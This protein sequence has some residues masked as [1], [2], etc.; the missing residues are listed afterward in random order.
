[1]N[2]SAIDST[3]VSVLPL[4]SLGPGDAGIAGAKAATLARLLRAGFPVPD[5]FVV[6][7][8]T[9]VTADS[10]RAAI[11]AS[12]RSLGGGPV[13]VRSSAV[14]EDLDDASFAGQYETILGVIGIDAVCEAIAAVRASAGSLRID[15]YRSERA[16]GAEDGIGVLVQ[17]LVPATASGVAFTA[18]PVSGD[19]T[20]VRVSAVR[21]LG[22]RLVG[23]E[24]QADEWRVEAGIAAAVRDRQGAIDANLA[25]AVADLARRIEA[26]EGRPQDIE[27]AAVDGSI[28]VLQARPMTA[29]P[30][31]VSWDPGHRGV[32]LRNFRLGEWLG[33]PV[34]PLFETWLLSRLESRLNRNLAATISVA[35][36][37]PEHLV[38]NGWY[39]YGFNVIPSRPARMLAMMLRHVLPSLLRRPRRAAMAFPP[40]ARFGVGLAER[41]WRERVAPRY[42]RAVEDADRD[43][44]TADP[45]RLV[46]IVDE[47]ADAAG[48]YFTSITMVAGFASKSE[49]PLARFHRRYLVAETGGSHLD[50]LSGLGASA[51]APRRHAVGSIDWFAP[52]IAETGVA[53]DASATVQ[54][55][56]AARQRRQAAEAVAR[57]ALAGASRLRRFE[58]L[59]G[60]AQRYAVIR[61]EM[62]AEFTLAWPVLRRAV[63]RLGRLLV[64][65]GVLREPD[66]VFF[67]TRGDLEAT[68]GGADGERSTSARACRREWERQ[69]RLVP[70]LVIGEMPPMLARVLASAEDAVRGAPH[71]QPRTD[72]LVGIPASAGRATGPV[73]IVHSAEDLDRVRQGDVLVSPLTAPAWT[74]AF[75]RIV[76]VVTDTGSVA[77]HAS[78]VARE[79]G[80]PAVVGTGEA[81]RRLQEG[82][83]IE[84]DGSAGVVRPLAR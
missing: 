55:H 45:R 68:L 48:E 80:L 78:I 66:E 44:E 81:T 63:L 12:L 75:D 22:D 38:I 6:T 19:R 69:R 52:T 36:P 40:L 18:D 14:A 24:E 83:L 47:L 61:E 73:R 41:E 77:A 76:A 5:G 46:Q 60:T 9:D 27:W 79:Y 32:W 31:E 13:A 11:E 39:F 64:E 51:P 71:S 70:P 50:L 26:V 34:T 57:R 8:E 37:T 56:E 74:V 16:P 17:A 53:S 35:V 10:T 43:V 29:L 72:D 42:R 59:L 54:R 49:I 30:D 58:R 20:G 25:V 1:V 3:Q 28:F 33:D 21:G 23:G 84:V 15:R 67:I 2:V 62:A 7:S 4:T 65:R 82:Q